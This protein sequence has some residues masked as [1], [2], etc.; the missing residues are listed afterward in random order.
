VFTAAITVH[1]SIFYKSHVDEF[2][3]VLLLPGDDKEVKK[4]FYASLYYLM[5]GRNMQ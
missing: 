2:A 3:I 1:K 4:L 5:M